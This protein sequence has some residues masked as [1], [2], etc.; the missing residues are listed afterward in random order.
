MSG[1]SSDTHQRLLVV[2]DDADLCE[3]VTQLLSDEGFEVESATDGEEA[4]AILRR[5]PCFDLIVLDLMMPKTD[6]WQFRVAQRTD[7]VLSA[8]PVV[9]MSASTTAQALAIDAD[10]YV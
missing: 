7:P 3:H 10:A 5:E 4:L 1:E 2:E 6:G 9:V 8:I